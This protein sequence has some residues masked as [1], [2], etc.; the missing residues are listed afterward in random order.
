MK[1]IVYSLLWEM[2]DFFIIR[3]LQGLGHGSTLDLMI[4]QKSLTPYMFSE[5]Y[6]FN[7]TEH[8]NLGSLPVIATLHRF[9][10]CASNLDVPPAAR[11]TL[12]C[13]GVRK[14]GRVQCAINPKPD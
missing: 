11:K 10:R 2:Q 9:F 6:T 12:A 8:E 13:L 5:A 3:I 14:A 7:P 4:N 1:T